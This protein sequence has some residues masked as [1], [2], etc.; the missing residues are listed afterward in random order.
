MKK[1]WLAPENAKEL[2]EI[3]RQYWLDRHGR[4]IDVTVENV[5]PIGGRA[6]TVIRSN[7]LDGMPR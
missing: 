2:A 4:R 3:I 5:G 7:L 6:V 1:D